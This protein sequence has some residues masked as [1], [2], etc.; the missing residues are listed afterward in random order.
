M[1]N[2]IDQKGLRALEA[3]CIQEQAPPCQAG[4]PVHVDARAM[5]AQI[6]AG[7]FAAAYQTFSKTVPFPAIISRVC[8]QPCRA[9]CTRGEIGDPIAIR[10]LEQACVA[11]AGDAPRAPVKPL[12]A[13]G[14]R[15]AVVGG[16]LSGLTAAFDLARKGWAVVVFEAAQ[17]L[18]GRLWEVAE[19]ALPRHI[20]E[21]DFAAT[22]LATPGLEV[23]LG[24]AVEDA[25]AL[26]DSFDAVYI[27]TGAVRGDAVDP[28]TCET[29]RAG[30]FARAG[31]EAWSPITSIADGR[32][33]AIS[34]DRC[35]QNVSL[36]ASRQHEGAYTT[37]LYTSTEGIAPA[38]AVPL[39]DARA[40]YSRDQATEEAR[41][42]IHCECLECV[43]VCE[44]LARYDGYPKQYARTIYNNL[45]IVMGE[46]HANTFI[47]SCALCGL[48]AEVCPTDF[49]MGA[50]CRQ[51][52]QVMVAQGRMPPSTHEFALRDMAFSNGDQFAMA[53]H[54][55]GTDASA[56]LFFPG[57]QLAA[58]R[59]GDVKA[60]YAHL[61]EA[62]EGGVGLAL[63][64]CGA[65]AEWAGRKDLFEETMERF[66]AQHA[67]LG[68]PKLALACSSC[69]Q[70]FK[71]H[72]PD[73][74]LIS[75]WDL[76]DRVGLPVQAAQPASRTLA[77]HDPCTA[78]YERAMQDGARRIIRRLGYRIEELPLSREKTTCCSYGGLMGFA[79]R[80]LARAVIERRINESRADYVTYCAVC[81]D[82][83][84]AQGKPTFHL[85]DLI[86]GRGDDAA[87][88]GRGPGYSQRHENRARLKREMLR[89]VWGEDVTTAQEGYE[90]IKLDV[91]EAVQ[92][93]LEDRLILVEDIQ[94]VI[95]FA[96]RTG[97]RL[98]NT[99]TGRFLAHY[100]PAAV[101]YW[102]EYR[103]E[104]DHYAV[105]NAYSHRMEVAEET[106]DE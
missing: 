11:L 95:A 23:R 75:L 2:F 85:L 102:V 73:I 14:K 9:V 24:A 29:A 64:C 20:I 76:L 3:R 88:A 78:R 42:C 7:D 38:R 44:Y 17:R 51:A 4:C 66:R 12:P 92:A 68:R 100:R 97:R 89:E 16:G 47:N 74:E 19:D 32:R 41:R 98:L 43:K 5:L 80:E 40:G 30:V 87:A 15:V 91:A 104:G 72:A 49:D 28:L 39:P 18:G 26:R 25:P 83:F 52:R 56:Y 58:S 13:R 86:F 34:I 60:L 106:K 22:V 84:A 63:G 50:L 61:R 1:T 54:A 90:S 65:P 59:P 82:F 105:F 21:R 62:L 99:D 101:T 79:D 36:T 93:R 33:A 45:S 53:R 103:P 48:C 55:P 35:L 27:S 77:V 81:R 8:D 37:T 94:Q 57:C 10:A 31:S 6:G 46:R 69:C 71:T 70:V 67:A 96:E